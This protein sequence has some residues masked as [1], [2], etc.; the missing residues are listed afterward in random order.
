ML[1][2]P[3]NHNPA[4]AYLRALVSKTGL[5][6]RGC[7]RAL[8]VSERSFRYWLRGKPPIPYAAQYA[9]EQL[10]LNPHASG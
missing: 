1:P 3:A 4:P 7:A 9:L 6:Q 8:G 5:S 10:A 2:N